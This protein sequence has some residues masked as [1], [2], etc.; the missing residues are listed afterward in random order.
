MCENNIHAIEGAIF[1]WT[2]LLASIM[3][4][5]LSGCQAAMLSYGYWLTARLLSCRV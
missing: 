2:F 4:V 3:G 5:A 1:I